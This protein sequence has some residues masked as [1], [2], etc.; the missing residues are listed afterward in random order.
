MICETINGNIIATF[1]N[2]KQQYNFESNY[3]FYKLFQLDMN[4]IICFT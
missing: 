4:L 1:Q 2:I 3:A